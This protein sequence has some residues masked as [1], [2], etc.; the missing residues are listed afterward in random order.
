MNVL[1]IKA[2]GGY[3]N[4]AVESAEAGKPGRYEVVVK[5]HAT[6]LNY[7][8]LMVV[9]GLIPTEDG[10]IPMSD[11]AGEII[12]I[13]SEVS[14]WNIGDKVMSLFFPK[15]DSGKPTPEK[16]KFYIWRKRPWFCYCCI[17]C[18]RK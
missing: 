3:E 10:R 13:G 8:D 9:K 1:K 5:W 2:P 11:G 16:T 18:W 12:E 14:Q 4:I 15:W 7:H 6:S 17:N